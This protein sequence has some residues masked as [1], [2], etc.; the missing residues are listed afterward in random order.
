MD[1]KLLYAF[2]IAISFIVYFYRC[3]HRTPDGEGILS[4]SDGIITGMEDKDMLIVLSPFDVHCIRSPVDG[5][6]I[7][8]SD[9]TVDINKGGKTYTVALMQGAILKTFKIQIDVKPGD[10]INRGQKIGRI[11]LG[12]HVRFEL[13]DGQRWTKKLGEIVFGGQ[14]IIA[15]EV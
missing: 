1:K 5:E 10:V 9:N 15:T 11:L 13:P 12:S 2:S 14:T 7:N 6:V 4:P 3:P 8:V